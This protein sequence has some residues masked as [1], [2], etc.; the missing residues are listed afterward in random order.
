[1]RIPSYNTSKGL[2]LL[3]SSTHPFVIIPPNGEE[4][5]ASLPVVTQNILIV[6]IACS[7]LLGQL[8][9]ALL[10][11]FIIPVTPSQPDLLLRKLNTQVLMSLG[12]LLH[13]PQPENQRGGSEP[14]N[15][16]CSTIQAEQKL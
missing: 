10:M 3:W 13:R 4:T 9:D 12:H 8:P 2:N 7:C 14:K 16:L 11:V 1:M 15:I 6:G 5:E